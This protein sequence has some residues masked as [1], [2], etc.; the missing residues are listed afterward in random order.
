MGLD[1][2]QHVAEP[3][4][5]VRSDRFAFE[6]AADRPYPALV[7]RHAEMVRPEPDEALGET[8][9]SGKRRVDARPRVTEIKLLRDGG[10]GV[11]PRR[12]WRRWRAR[13]LGWRH[14]HLRVGLR[15]CAAGILPSPLRDPL[16]G[17]A[18]GTLS[19]LKFEG[20]TCGGGG[21][22][23]AVIGEEAGA[24]TLKLGEKH[25]ARVGRDG[26]NRA[27]AGSKAE[28]IECQ[29]CFGFRIGGHPGMSFRH[30]RGVAPRRGE[31]SAMRVSRLRQQ[32]FRRHGAKMKNRKWLSAPR[33]Y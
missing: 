8:D 1:R 2:L 4:E 18:R 7:G 6:G 12:G 25:A 28:P 5:H 31:A 19:L 30:G 11:W 14:A 27:G 21:G 23:Q 24:G 10:T 33:R 26:G 13:L 16:L 9:I 20:R 29:G 3:A 22:R 32:S 17:L 15:R